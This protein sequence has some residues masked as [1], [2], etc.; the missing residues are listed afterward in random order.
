MAAAAVVESRGMDSPS[1]FSESQ[2]DTDDIIFPCKGCGEVW[3]AMRLH[4]SRAV[5]DP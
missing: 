5:A 4:T 1:T 2:A 3:R